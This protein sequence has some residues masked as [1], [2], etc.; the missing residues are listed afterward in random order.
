MAKRTTKEK[1]FIRLPEAK[2]ERIRAM[3]MSWSYDTKTFVR[4]RLN[5]FTPSPR[6]Y[7]ILNSLGSILLLK[8]KKKNR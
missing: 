8:K 7:S 3:A 2:I 5:Q 6:I 1:T 4:S